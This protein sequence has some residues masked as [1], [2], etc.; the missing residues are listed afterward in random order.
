MRLLSFFVFP[1]PRTSRRTDQPDARHCM[2]ASAFTLRERYINK[3]I[4]EFSSTFYRIKS[5]CA[6]FISPNNDFAV[7]YSE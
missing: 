5:F 3:Q 7:K 1:A 6:A 4:I 2:P